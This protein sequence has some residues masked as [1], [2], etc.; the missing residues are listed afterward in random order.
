MRRAQ[1]ETIAD[2][3]AVLL[4]VA[5]A[6]LPAIAYLVMLRRAAPRFPLAS[7]ATARGFLWGA[8]A[9]IV[10]ALVLYG[11]VFLLAAEAPNPQRAS[12]FRWFP[13][14]QG[15]GGTEIL[16]AVVAA[17]F[18][19]EFAKGL[20]VWLM[21][22]RI[23]LLSDGIVLGSACGLGFAAT[24]NLAYFAGPFLD[25]NI[26]ALIVLA[27]LRSI[28]S[29]PLHATATAL[30]GRGVAAS[31]L[32]K[33]NGFMVLCYLGAVAIHAIFNG[34]VVGVSQLGND[35]FLV[36][37]LVVAVLIGY[38][39]LKAVRQAI[40]VHDAAAAGRAFAPPGVVRNG[41][42]TP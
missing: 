27:V 19:E 37:A 17:P 24:E 26:A 16:L 42:R 13:W 30:T 7:G 6:F 9:A 35:L 18:I 36:L 40:E 33:R 8:L 22:K 1:G 21:K 12:F 41:Q 34:I 4:L 15:K 38:Y 20:G 25:G 31:V 39:G 29:A 5:I 14:A 32:E 11:L 23:R 28:A 3:L 2:W 10:L